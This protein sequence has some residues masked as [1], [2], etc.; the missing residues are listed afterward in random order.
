MGTRSSRFSQSLHRNRSKI[1]FVYQNE[2]FLHRRHLSR[3]LVIRRS[4]P[5]PKQT[6]GPVPRLFHEPRS[7]R[8]IHPMFLRK[9][10]FFR[11]RRKS[12]RIQTSR[13]SNHLRFRKSRRQQKTPTKIHQS[14]FDQK[15]QP[16][17]SRKTR[18]ERSFRQQRR[19][20][21]RI[22]QPSQKQRQRR[23]SQA[24]FE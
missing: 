9:T 21:G 5:R 12:H 7:S 3:C 16:L 11:R 6:Y 23:R 24:I 8:T 1:T 4:L 20:H 15:R 18:N 17:R 19:N 10:R 22:H 13:L 14:H 2:T